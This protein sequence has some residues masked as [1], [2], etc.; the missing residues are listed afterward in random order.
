MPSLTC[1]KATLEGAG[2]RRLLVQFGTKRGLEFASLADLRAYATELDADDL[3][4][5]LL[6][7]WWLRGEGV[8]R[9]ADLQGKTITL[10]LDPLSLTVD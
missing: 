4:S 9:L 8:P 6:L 5:R 2:K 1:R 3:L 10:T 7:A